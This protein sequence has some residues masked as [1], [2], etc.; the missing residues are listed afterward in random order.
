MS[1]WSLLSWSSSSVPKFLS[2]TMSPPCTLVPTSTF[3]PTAAF[4]IAAGF[5]P[6]SRPFLHQCFQADNHFAGHYKDDD[7]ENS[8]SDSDGDGKGGDVRDDDCDDEDSDSDRDGEVDRGEFLHALI[9]AEAEEK[10]VASY[11]PEM[12]E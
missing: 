8:D 9:E 5:I 1:P 6:S 11:D 2:M 4:T 10:P 7:S 3:A 12:E